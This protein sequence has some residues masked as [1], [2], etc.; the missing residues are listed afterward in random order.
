MKIKKRDGSL[1]GFN[2]D[3]I[4]TAISKAGYVDDYTKENIAEYIERI[5]KETEMTVEDIQDRKSVV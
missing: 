2:K 1:V 5:A 4:I 3:K